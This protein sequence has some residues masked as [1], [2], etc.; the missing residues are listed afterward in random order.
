MGRHE[1]AHPPFLRPFRPRDVEARW[2][3]G[4]GEDEGDVEGSA[5]GGGGCRRG[6]PI[7]AEGLGVVPTEDEALHHH[8]AREGRGAAEGPAPAA[9]M[10]DSLILWRCRLGW[11]RKQGR[12][13]VRI[14]ET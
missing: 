8:P 5:G 3:W 1:V 14:W 9:A 11:T 12:G 6:P 2:G 7:L 4:L 13:A 10:I